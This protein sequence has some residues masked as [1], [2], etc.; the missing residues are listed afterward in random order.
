MNADPLD[1][2][3]AIALALPEA[4]EQI[5]WD[6]P[7]FRV[8]G[9]IFGIFSDEPHEGPRVSLKAPPGVQ[10]MLVEADAARFFVPPYTGHK[11][12]IGVRLSEGTDWDEVAALVTRSWRM[13]APA[14]LAA[15]LPED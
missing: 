9:K 13:T 2:L 12:W 15:T 1:Q 5:T 6:H 14:R 10:A 4:A 11:G 3:R 8:R 7:T